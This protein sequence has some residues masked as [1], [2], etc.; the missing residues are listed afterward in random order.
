MR[1]FKKFMSLLISLSM[2]LA[3]VAVP[4]T[5]F[6]GTPAGEMDKTEGYSENRGDVVY[7]YI[8][9]TPASMDTGGVTVDSLDSLDSSKIEWEN[10]GL[11]WIAL[12]LE[13]MTRL[14]EMFHSTETANA[15][16][17]L[18]LLKL[19]LAYD[20]EYLELPA[21]QYNSASEATKYFLSNEYP[22]G[23]RSHTDA[24]YTIEEGLDVHYDFLVTDSGTIKPLTITN[25]DASK[26]NVIYI[27]ARQTNA[28]ANDGLLFMDSAWFNGVQKSVSD[29]PYTLAY[30]TLKMKGDEA[31]APGTRIIQEYLGKTSTSVTV[32]TG[33]ETF[34]SYEYDVR[35]DLGGT[36]GDTNFSNRFNIIADSLDLFPATGEAP[37]TYA[38]NI[39]A[40]ANGS[41]AS[42]KQGETAVNPTTTGG[43]TYNLEADKT[44]TVT[45]TPSTGY[46]FKGW[47][48]NGNNLTAADSTTQAGV[49]VTPSGST[50]TIEIDSTTIG[51]ATSIPAIIAV[52]EED[53][54]EFTTGVNNNSL[55]SVAVYEGTEATGTALTN[56]GTDNKY[57]LTAGTTYTVK[58]TKTND[59]ATLTGWVATPTLDLGGDVKIDA[60]NSGGYTSD[61]VTFVMPSGNQTLTA[62]YVLPTADITAVAA[63]HGDYTYTV[64]GTDYDEGENANNVTAGTEIVIT[65]AGATSIVVK[66]TN[67]SNTVTDTDSNDDTFTFL[68]PAYG[69]TITVTYPTP[70]Y[71]ITAN[72]PAANGTYTYKVADGAAVNAG[73][74][75]QAEANQ[76][77]TITPDPEDGY[78]VD[79]ITVT[80]ASGAVAVNNNAFTMPAYDV[81]ITVTFK[82]I[83]P[84]TYDI[85]IGSA[86][87]ATGGGIKF[88]IGGTQYTESKTDITTAGQTITVI[89]TPVAGYTAAVTVTQT[90]NGSVTVPVGADNTFTMP[91]YDVTITVTYSEILYTGISA[92]IDNLT[93]NAAVQTPV[94]EITGAT[95]TPGTDYTVTYSPTEIKNAGSYTATITLTETA[96]N[97]YRFAGN[98]EST[99]VTFNINPYVIEELTYDGGLT[100]VYDGTDDIDI[101]Q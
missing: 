58:T 42:V 7:Q 1:Q 51:T 30:I 44:Y 75:S 69:V 100:K 16:A 24:L 95:L 99:T 94:V 96:K 97:T 87:G 31:P 76:T 3:M 43:T 34:T 72:T 65:A 15:N 88:A 70:K 78:M 74:N 29:D 64:G 22:K 48:Y 10:G 84:E 67:G 73:T 45:A 56:N 54:Y 11:I 39:S 13:N 49:T 5:A 46:R 89:P 41:I 101:V 8:G 36:D 26:I 86:T 27:A 82:E 50:L 9:T 20:T 21:E 35:R 61:T 59:N 77:V 23:G 14:K 90:G 83:P 2:I 68:M 12:K 63:D 18:D 53:T 71:D 33:G 93:Y 40:G 19:S 6:A 37:T 47:T 38:A 85:T 4:Q 57:N 52:F 32:G 92:A 28:G 91:A 98:A 17:G 25:T 66:E 80:G 62:V 60:T 79:T 55:G 81:T